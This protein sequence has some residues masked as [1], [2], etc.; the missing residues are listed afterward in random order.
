ME[1]IGP[2]PPSGTHRYVVTV[3]ALRSPADEYPGDFD[4]GGND[5]DEIEEKLDM[6]GG[7]SGNIMV[8]M[9]LQQRMFSLVMWMLTL[10]LW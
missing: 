1:Y 4:A 10:V 2:Y 6:A 9:S 3:Y 8:I 7:K 5:I